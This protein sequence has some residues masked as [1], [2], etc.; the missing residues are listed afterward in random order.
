MSPQIVWEG[1]QFIHG[2]RSRPKGQAAR[3]NGQ[4]S[5]RHGLS[6]PVAVQDILRIIE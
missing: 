2:D 4:F 1:S 6:L 3:H 5:D